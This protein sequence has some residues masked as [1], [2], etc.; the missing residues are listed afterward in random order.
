MVG[1]LNQRVWLM[2]KCRTSPRSKDQDLQR[3]CLRKHER[4]DK[5]NMHEEGFFS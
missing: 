5:E 3:E 4:I 1:V 2:Q